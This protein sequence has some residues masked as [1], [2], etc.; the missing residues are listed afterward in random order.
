MSAKILSLGVNKVF[1]KKVVSAILDGKKAVL[2][3]NYAILP[4]SCTCS[5][6]IVSMNSFDL[7]HW[8]NHLI[9][10][11]QMWFLENHTGVSVWPFLNLK[12]TCKVSYRSRKITLATAPT[13]T[14]VVA[15]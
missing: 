12:S 4:I 1:I 5:V 14:L 15:D 2:L 7:V 13:L 9:Q 11:K 3:N 8:W 10:T 6:S